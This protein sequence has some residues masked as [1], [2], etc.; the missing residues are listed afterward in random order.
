MSGKLAVVTGITGNQGGSVAKAFLDAGFKVR[1]ISRDPS[2]PSGKKW[3]D[4]GVE[5]VAGDFD[6]IETLKSAF[7]GANYIFGN[8]DFWTNMGN[9]KVH[10]Q[11]AEQNKPASDI[12]KAMEVQQ[13][14]N[15]IDA[16]NEVAMDT[17]DL[18]ILSTLSAASKWS[19]GKYTNAHHFDSKAMVVEYLNETP[20]LEELRKKTSL[21]H[22][23][24]F[25]NN[26]KSDG[27]VFLRPR[28]QPDGTYLLRV[29]MS[30]ERKIPMG[31]PTKIA[32]NFVVA[33]T[34]VE[35]GKT[36]IASAG[37]LTM[38]EWCEKVGKQIGKT[39]KYEVM[40]RAELE[41]MI[42]G[43]VGTEMADMFLYY[44]DFG[45]DGGDPSVIYPDQLGVD[46][47]YQTADEYFEEED[48]SKLTS[49]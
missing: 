3:T 14:K 10:Q 16:I 31:D 47:K 36:I 32:G 6:H 38:P 33:L 27:A 22:M 41:E 28:K 30:G 37:M 34:K 40:P 11:A 23:P 19:K 49:E 43:G 24:F 20:G 7:K 44:Q 45:Y 48:F 9:P 12:A 35:P 2:K 26:W 18:F 46:V 4:L 42:P 21:I 29:P 25:I 5:L 39:I 17:L 1:G 15:M 8:T 13:G